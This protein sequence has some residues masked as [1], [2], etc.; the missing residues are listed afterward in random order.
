MEA[1]KPWLDFPAQVA[2]L[3]KRGLW[4]ED[5]KRAQWYLRRIGYYRLSGYF[6]VLR[7]WDK[8]RQILLDNFVAGSDFETVL[9]LYLFDKKLR[10]L[11]LDALE[12]IEMAVRVDMVHILGAYEPLAHT[13]A[14]YLHGNF[15]KRIQKDGKTKHEAW[16]ARYK[17]L[18]QKAHKRRLEF[19]AHN[20][21]KYGC[22]PVWAA[23]CLWDFGSMSRLY[24]GMKYADKNQIALK[25]GAGNGDILAQW[26]AG[27][28][29]IRNISAHH[30]R[31][32]NANISR[33]AAPIRKD[34]FW[35]QLDQTRPFF[36][37]CLMQLMMKV[38]CPQSRWSER[39]SALLAEFPERDGYGGKMSLS[40]FGLVPNWREWDL[41]QK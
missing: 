8:E 14:E 10:L 33:M 31:L 6:H 1:I 17:V 34:I 23:S 5:E 36:Y 41:W 13:K 40:R 29:E 7:Q 25:Y 26:L 21:S 3:Q 11:A 32:W 22:L 27:L 37:F 15:S 35:Q 4:V 19:V 20:L 16:L 28:N 9:S 2:L 30:D 18:E 24:E 12:R 38:L 39:F